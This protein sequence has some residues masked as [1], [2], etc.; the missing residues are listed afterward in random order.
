MGGWR[1]GSGE[2]LPGRKVKQKQLPHAS[3]ATQLESRSGAGLH[4][5]GSCVEPWASRPVGGGWGGFR[6]RPSSCPGSEAWR[7]S[8]LD[9]VRASGTATRVWGTCSF[10]CSSEGLC[11]RRLGHQRGW[12]NGQ[13]FP[14]CA[15]LCV[16][17][18]RGGGV[19]GGGGDPFITAD[20]NRLG[21][22]VRMWGCQRGP[23]S[24]TLLVLTSNYRTMTF[25]RLSQE[26]G[27][28]RGFCP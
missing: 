25:D 20:S 13:I 5:R 3:R 8:V 7:G 15:G 22:E 21:V 17:V 19:G 28:S 16:C 11:P 2:P 18:S 1:V 6:G 14:K 27:G 9:E 12:G 4:P 10:T 26:A 24:K 23:G